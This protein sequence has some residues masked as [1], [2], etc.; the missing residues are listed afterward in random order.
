MIGFC[1]PQYKLPA[2]TFLIPVPL[3]PIT[4]HHGVSNIPNKEADAARRKAFSNI[5]QGV[6]RTLT[7]YCDL[8]LFPFGCSCT[9]NAGTEEEEAS[10]V[11]CLSLCPILL[12]LQHGRILCNTHWVAFCLCVVLAPPQKAGKLLQH[13]S[14]PCTHQMAYVCFLFS[15]PFILLCLKW[16]FIANHKFTHLHDTKED[17][18][19][20]PN[21]PVFKF[22]FL[23]FLQSLPF[24]PS[25]DCFIQSSPLQHFLK[26][27]VCF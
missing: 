12:L 7:H 26:L 11:I 24:S 6:P 15:L 16:I 2:F 17:P 23:T 3:S 14:N 13:I 10:F 4:A 25:Y 19:I 5:C 1:E 18:C 22:S 9:V 8:C 21:K 20:W 27:S